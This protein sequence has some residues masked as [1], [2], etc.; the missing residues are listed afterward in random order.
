MKELYKMLA[1]KESKKPIL[2]PTASPAEP[3]PRGTQGLK[4]SPTLCGLATCNLIGCGERGIL[5]RF[6]TR[7][8]TLIISALFFQKNA[9]LPIFVANLSQDKAL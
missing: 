4:K 9:I 3:N 7:R 8:N 1:E 2:R 5:Y 6:N